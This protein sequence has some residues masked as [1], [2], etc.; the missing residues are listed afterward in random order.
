MENFKVGDRVIYD[1][2]EYI[3]EKDMSYNCYFI[4][5]EDSFVEM[6]PIAM[7]CSCSIRE[8]TL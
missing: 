2:V 4:G 3:I 6:V 8:K 1:D 5:N 7:L